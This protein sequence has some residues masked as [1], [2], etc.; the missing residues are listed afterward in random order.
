MGILLAAGVAGSAFLLHGLAHPTRPPSG[1]TK[2]AATR[3]TDTGKKYKGLNTMI[4][5]GLRWRSDDGSILMLVGSMDVRKKKL[6]FLRIG[7]FNE[8]VLKDVKLVLPENSLRQVK[9]VLP[10]VDVSQPKDSAQQVEVVSATGGAPLPNDSSRQVVTT[11]GGAPQPKGQSSASGVLPC[12][13]P[14]LRA[15]TGMAA[16]FQEIFT[17]SSK[18]SGLT[19]KKISSVI[20]ENFSMVVH[21]EAQDREKCVVRCDRISPE[22][23]ASHVCVVMKGDVQFENN[24]GETLQC[25]KAVIRSGPPPTVIAQDAHLT[26]SNS[27]ATFKKFCFPVIS[28]RLWGDIQ[29][30]RLPEGQYEIE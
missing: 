3:R 14:S 1:Q 25:E 22:L 15:S 26:S 19:R 9:G 2:D 11:T 24:Q 23:S 20:V 10:V 27:V 5:R 6:G 16:A 30:K 12:P 7:A 29:K 8:M 4:L 18:V 28:E 17:A 13:S 21:Q